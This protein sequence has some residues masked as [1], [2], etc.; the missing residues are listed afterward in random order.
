MNLFAKIIDDYKDEF[1]TL[2]HIWNGAFPQVVT[3]FRGK[4]KILPNIYDEAFT[5]YD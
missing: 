3:A 1:K 2:S 5:D 4:F